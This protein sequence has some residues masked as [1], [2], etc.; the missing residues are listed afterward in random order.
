MSLMAIMIGWYQLA[1]LPNYSFG[2]VD[3]LVLKAE[4]LHALHDKHHTVSV[5]KNMLFDQ[6]IRYKVEEWCRAK[7]VILFAKNSMWAGDCKDYTQILVHYLKR[8]PFLL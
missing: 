8:E 2:S 1:K 4:Y 3:Y 6:E 5:E 7:N